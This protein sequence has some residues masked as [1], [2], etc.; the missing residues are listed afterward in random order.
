[1]TECLI[2]RTKVDA[3]IFDEPEIA[4]NRPTNRQTS[5]WAHTQVV[6]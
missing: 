2:M 1:M 4:G 6:E 3:L 5:D